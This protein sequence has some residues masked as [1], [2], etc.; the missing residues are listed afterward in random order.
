[1]LTTVDTMDSILMEILLNFLEEVG[2][3]QQYYVS[4]FLIS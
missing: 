4:C 1:M 3:E 2:K